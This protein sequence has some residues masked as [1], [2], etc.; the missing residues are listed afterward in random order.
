[1]SQQFDIVIVG[2]GTAG[3]ILANRLSANPNI[4]VALIEAGPDTPPNHQDEVIWDSYPNV[5]YFDPRHHW[6][7][8]RVCHQGPDANGQRALRRYEQARVMGGGSSINGMMANRGAPGDYDAWATAGACGWSW[9]D[10]LPYFRRLETDLDFNG[11][12]HGSDGPVPIRRVRPEAWPGFTKAVGKAIEEGGLP[13]IDDQNDGTFEPAYFPITINNKDDRRVSAADAY[14]TPPVRLRANLEIYADTVALRLLHE[15]TRITGVEVRDDTGHLRQIEAREVVLAAGALHSPALL[16]RA[17]IGPGERLRESGIE[18][19]ADRRGVGA[20]LQ[21]HP[22]I[23]VSGW[24]APEARQPWSLR[25][26]IFAGY[27][28]SSNVPGCSPVDMYGVV[29][30]RGAWHHVGRKLG[31]FLVW[32]NKAYSKGVVR[33]AGSDPDLEP[34]VGFNFLSDKRDLLRLM[35]ALTRIA[36]IY[37]HPE[38]RAVAPN[39]F[40]SSYTERSR[41]LAIVTLRNRL[42]PIPWSWLLDAPAPLRGRAFERRVSGGLLLESMIS[43]L[44][45]LESFVRERAHGTWH[46][47]GTCRM[48]REDNPEAVTD[49]EGKVIGV[50]GLR[51]ADASVMPEVPCANTNLPVMM[52]AEKMS[53]AILDDWR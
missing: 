19:L 5:A 22:Q 34:E 45:R 23:A 30:N 29:V 38:V 1:M 50:R 37:Q 9:A 44:S 3:C 18:V 53:D 49:S 33:V 10:V 52:V 42:E 24:L 47:C 40:P 17:G 36:L 8:L 4:R 46:A 48:G 32:V 21:E 7:T 16:Q 2:G 31:G 28:Y 25:R 26:H 13:Y 41:D 15:G 39:P 35:D 27:R 12:V 20:N 11:P 14:L 51:V 6:P 43:D